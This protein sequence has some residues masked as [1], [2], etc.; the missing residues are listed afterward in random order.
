MLDLLVQVD[1][2]FA[3]VR[4]RLTE[5]GC[6]QNEVTETDPSVQVHIETVVECV[7]GPGGS[8]VPCKGDKVFEANVAVAGEVPRHAAPGGGK[9]QNDDQKRSKVLPDQ[10]SMGN[11]VL[12]TREKRDCK[13]L[14]R[15]KLDRGVY[16]VPVKSTGRL[17]C[18]IPRS[19]PRVR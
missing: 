18:R 12:H 4:T 17:P 5:S 9:R 10:D 7:V 14:Q 6:K 2:I 3:E 19:N 13:T 8:E 15:P 16:V 11:H 1:W